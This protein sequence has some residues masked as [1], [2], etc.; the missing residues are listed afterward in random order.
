MKEQAQDLIIVKD[1]DDSKEIKIVIKD[2]E[3]ILTDEKE[4]DDED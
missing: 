4:P 2:R 3:D 1:E